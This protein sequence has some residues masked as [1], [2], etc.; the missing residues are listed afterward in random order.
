MLNFIILFYNNIYNFQNKLCKKMSKKEIYLIILISLLSNSFQKLNRKV[1][2]ATKIK[3][4]NIKNRIF[5][6]AMIDN[7]FLQNDRITE[8]A[9]NYYEKLSREG[10]SIIFTAGTIVSPSLIY[11]KVGTF[12][13]D[14]DDYIE[15]F[16]K[17]T[18][19]VHKNNANILLDLYHPGTLI[20][21][22]ADKAYGPS[23]LRHPYFNENSKELTK[24]DILKI[25]D[26]FEKGAIRAKKAGFDGIEI[27]AA[28]LTLL[29]QFLSP[30]FNKRNDEYG[31]NDENRA[32][33]IV[34][35]IEKIRKSVGN[36]FIISIKLN[37]RDGI[38]N[39][40]RKEGFITACKLIEKAGA[41]IIQVS[42]DFNHQPQNN[43]PYFLSQTEEI[44][45][46]VN[47]PV[48]LIGGIR[49]YEIIEKVLEESNVQYFALGRPLNC[50][51][52][53]VLRW[54]KGDKAKSQCISCNSCGKN[55][56]R[57]CF[58]KNK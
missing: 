31:G 35:I 11:G 27:H 17:L 58:S 54:E 3:N 23:N 41:D 56:S 42:G 34:E 45:D 52:D 40:I 51:P 33:I 9:Y 26:D 1:F 14:K 4:L 44:A 48:V 49:N 10:T 55:G 37:C 18:N 19:L 25:E 15:D 5:K 28:H 6:A 38:E 57:K 2:E 39:G 12:R 22:K 43:I 53:L 8:E 21:N 29:S 24:E 7:C 16:K 47:I 13:I 46:I 36:D 50:E 20:V 32:R 30:A